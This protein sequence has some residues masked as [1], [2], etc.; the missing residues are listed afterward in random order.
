MIE[1]SGVRRSW[2]IDRSSRSSAR[3]FVEG[4]RPSRL[5]LHPVPLPGQRLQLGE[6]AVGFLPAP[7]RFEGA[8]EP[9]TVLL[10]IAVIANAAN[11]TQFCSSTIMKRCNGGIWKKLKA[12]AGD[13]RQQPPNAAPTRRRSRESPADTRP[14][15]ETTGATSLRG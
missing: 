14:P 9:G 7:L 11:A 4:P 10:T 13:R 8:C 2:E 1:V 5:R 12:T 3:R 15:R 6:G